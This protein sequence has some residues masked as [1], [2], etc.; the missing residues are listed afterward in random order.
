MGGAKAEGPNGLVL[1]PIGR[2][3]T[4]NFLLAVYGCDEIIQQTAGNP[5]TWTHYLLA[6]FAVTLGAETGLATSDVVVADIYANAITIGVGNSNV[7]TEIISPS[8]TAPVSG[9]KAS[10]RMDNVGSQFV[11]ILGVRNSSASQ[12]NC[13]ARRF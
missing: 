1:I 3:T 5:R 12:W 2:A 4:N 13:L 8:T 10:I 11:K 9:N 6:S 7:S